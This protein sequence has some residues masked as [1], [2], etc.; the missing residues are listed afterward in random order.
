MTATMDA[1]AELARVVVRT[2]SARQ[3]EVSALLRFGGGLH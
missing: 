1:K 3:A 2:P